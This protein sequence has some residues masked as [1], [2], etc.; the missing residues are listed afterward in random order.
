MLNEIMKKTSIAGLMMGHKIS[1]P[2]SIFEPKTN[3]EKIAE[4]F[5]NLEYLHLANKAEDFIE[6]FKYVIILFISNFY[7]GLGTRK[8]LNPY[9]GETL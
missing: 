6:K 4:F 5:G 8:P 9:L 7:Y 2:A 1:L 3:L